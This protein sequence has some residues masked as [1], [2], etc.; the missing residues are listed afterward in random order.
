MHQERRSFSAQSSSRRGLP[1]LDD[2]HSFRAV[3]IAAVV[4]THVIDYLEATNPGSASNRFALSFFQNGSVL[5]VFIAGLLFQYLSAGFDYRSY[6][7]NKW[8]FVIVPYLVASVPALAHQYVRRVGVFAPAHYH[9]NLLRTLLSSFVKASHLP[10]PLWFIPMISLFYVLAPLFLH[11]DR[12]TRSYAF[13]IPATSLVAGFVHR[14]LPL[15]RPLHAFAYFLPAYLAGM[16]TGRFYQRLKIWFA[17]NDVR[18]GLTALA[19]GLLMFEVVVLGR[20][21]ALWSRGTLLPLAF[22]TNLL[23]KLVSAVALLAWLSMS[24]KTLHRRLSLT[25]NLSFGVF[26]VHEYV[27]FALNRLL[28]SL[29]RATFPHIIVGTAI[30]LG[31]S[32]LVV[33]ATKRLSGRWSRYLVGC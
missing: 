5:F 25:A 33:M 11:I 31:T 16:A 30:V 8:R 32:L 1:H 28:P 20:G 21:G 7:S 2:V 6:L 24:P 15:D 19:L 18:W 14:P 29:P 23:L 3:A 22:D 12:K 4:A 10:R 9:G 27:L 13:L 17:R 26:F